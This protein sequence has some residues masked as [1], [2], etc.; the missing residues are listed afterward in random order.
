MS[1]WKDEMDKTVREFFNKLDNM[2]ENDEDIEVN[3]TQ[4]LIEYYKQ[5]NKK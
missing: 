2:L 4:E 5:N 1:N 3:S